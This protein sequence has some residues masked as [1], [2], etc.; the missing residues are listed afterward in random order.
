MARLVLT[1]TYDGSGFAGS[2]V[3]P[4]ARTVQGELERALATLR[5]PE[6]RT[7][8]AGRTDRAVHAA[9]QV[10]ACD[11][12]RPDLNDETLRAALNANLP[13]DIAVRH[14]ERRAGDFHPRFE[15]SWR[16]YRYRVWSGARAPLG[17]AFAWHRRSRLN[18]ETMATAASRFIGT[19]D[20]ATVAGGGDGVPWSDVRTR[21]RGTTRTVYACDCRQVSP[22]WGPADDGGRLFEI[23]VVADGF[24]PRMV[25]N[26][27]A[28]IVDVGRGVTSVD[29]IAELLSVRDRRAAG[30]TAPPH[31]LTLW[32]IGYSPWTASNGDSTNPR[33]SDASP[34]DPGGR[35]RAA[36]TG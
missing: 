5:F 23:H 35:D 1:V 33:L 26:I 3:Q 9:G 11:D 30:A 34:T 4:G 10:V 13:D 16:E 6:V 18:G 8:F 7:V 14:L 31:G 2:Q 15:A 17:R 19:N 28:I 36:A 32:Q 20:F 25:R 21:A 24:L 12:H 22:W 27:V 29:D